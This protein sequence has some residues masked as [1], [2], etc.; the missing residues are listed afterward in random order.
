MRSIDFILKRNQRLKFGLREDQLLNI[1]GASSILIK[2]EAGLPDHTHL[3]LAETLHRP[4]HPDLMPIPI[5]T[6][7]IDTS[8]LK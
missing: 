6:K 3:A 7:P 4:I 5:P 8:R 2:R 1:I